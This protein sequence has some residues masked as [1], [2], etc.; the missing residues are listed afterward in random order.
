[1]AYFGEGKGPIHM[2]NVRCT[3]M[4]RSLAD[5]IK[6]D[7]GRHNCRHGED[8]GVICDYP[9]MKTSSSSGTGESPGTQRVQ[10][11]SAHF[12]PNSSLSA[13]PWQWDALSPAP[14]AGVGSQEA[15][16]ARPEA[17]VHNRPS[18]LGSACTLSALSV[19]QLV[20]K[21]VSS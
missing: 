11:T 15:G 9:G 3:G 2:D 10:C 16:Q 21:A 6:R 12:S 20:D 8:A 4:E 14:C 7:F 18:G 1:M 19:S 5:C 13:K 17:G